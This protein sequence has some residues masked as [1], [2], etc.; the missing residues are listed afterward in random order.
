MK[1]SRFSALCIILATMILHSCGLNPAFAQDYG[2]RIRAEVQ[3]AGEESL[4]D[5]EFQQGSTPLIR[6]EPLDNG[7]PIDADTN[8]TVRMIIGPSA[9]N[10]YYASAS[11]TVA[12]NSYYLIQW[13]TIGTN[14]ANSVWWYTIYFEKNGY[15]YWNGNGALTI[16]ETT[17]TGDGLV[18]QDIVSGVG[19]APTDGTIYGRSNE[20]WVAI[21]GEASE[22]QA[23]L[24]SW[25]AATSNEFLRVIQVSPGVWQTKLPGEE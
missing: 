17:S 8:T 5:L 19:E 7:R 24:D 10:D 3:T 16:N 12:T 23:N 20:T 14:T 21:G 2:I 15:R 18:W 1:P 9:T 6:V 22:V 13:P 11:A 25:K 4:R